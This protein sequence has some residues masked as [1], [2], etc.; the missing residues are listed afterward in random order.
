MFGRGVVSRRECSRVRCRARRKGYPGRDH[1]SGWDN[2]LRRGILL[3]T[4][5]D[6]RRDMRGRTTCRDVDCVVRFEGLC[7]VAY[8]YARRR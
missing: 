8:G 1:Y 7:W 6:T 5:G 3:S 4:L 2:N